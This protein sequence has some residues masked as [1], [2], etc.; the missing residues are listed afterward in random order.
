M[1]TERARAANSSGMTSVP[2]ALPKAA[3][4]AVATAAA[5]MPVA[6]RAAAIPADGEGVVRGSAGG[7]VVVGAMYSPEGGKV[8]AAGGGRGCKRG[9]I[10]AG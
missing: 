3:S 4:H 7:M 9:R 6:L 1:E 5:S 8:Q 2:V 10:G